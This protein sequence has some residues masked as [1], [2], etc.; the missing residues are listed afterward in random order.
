MLGISLISFSAPKRLLK[1][2]V[3]LV[4]H[5]LEASALATA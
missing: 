5:A 1:P 4:D 3:A 2:A